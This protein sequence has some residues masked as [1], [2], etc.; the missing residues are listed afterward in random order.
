MDVDT[1]ASIRNLTQ[2]R[3][4]QLCFVCHNEGCHSSKHKGTP[5][6][7]KGN[8]SLPQNQRKKK[9]TPTELDNNARLASFM[10][11]HDISVEKALELLGLYYAHETNMEKTK[12]GSIRVTSTDFSLLTG[13][14]LKQG[15][16]ILVA[17]Q[18]VGGGE[19]TQ[20]TALVDS[21][22]MICCADID[23]ARRMKW[24]LKKIW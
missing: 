9:L 3:R 7:K 22:A 12:S 5:G 10:K 15:I 18:L 21:G 4:K 14:T 1:I 2:H 23:F 19:I 6:K 17:L 16:T 24:L 11:E 20:T 8:H 13:T